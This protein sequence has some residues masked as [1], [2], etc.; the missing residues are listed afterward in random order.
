MGTFLV[1]TYGTNGDVL[2]FIRIGQALR[3]RGHEVVLHT[4]AY[5]GDTARAAGLDFVPVDTEEAYAR[6]LHDAQH[7]LLNVLADVNHLADYYER[8]GLW[9][10]IRQE[11]ESMAALVRERDPAQVVAVSRHT[12]GLSVLMLRE[13]HRVPAAWLALSPTLFMAVP[14]TERLFPRTLAGPANRVRAAAGLSPVDDW[15]PWLSSADLQLGLW[16]RWFDAAGD[17]APDGAALPGFVLHDDAETGALP[18]EVRALVADGVPAERRPVL[19]TGGSGQLLHREWYRVAAEACARAGRPG[20]LVCRHRD[21][22]PESL[23][24]GVLWQPALPFRT[25]MPR[26]AAVVHHGGVLTCARAIASG[27]PQVIL[28]HGTDRPDNAARLRRLGLAEWLP[29]ARWTAS[30]AADLLTRVLDDPGYPARARERAPLVDSAAAVEAAC[31]RL[32]GLLGTRA[33]AV[34]PTT[35]KEASVRDRIQHL[36]PEQRAHLLKRLR[37]VPRPP[38]TEG[39]EERDCSY[40]QRRAWLAAQ[41]DPAAASA[42]VATAIRLRGPLD[43]AALAAAVDEVVAR[44]DGLRTVPVPGPEEP[45]QRVVGALRSPLRVESSVDAARWV[46]RVRADP[47]DL[48]RGPLVRTALLQAGPEESVFLLIGHHFVMDAASLGVVV[49]EVAAAYSARV[50]GGGPAF[51]GP[52]V[53]YPDVATHQRRTLAGGGLERALAHWRSTLDGL[54]PPP[55]LPLPPPATPGDVP[56]EAVRM[57]APELAERLSAAAGGSGR[58]SLAPALLTAYQLLLRRYTARDDVPVGVFAGGRTEPGTERVVGDFTNIVAVRADLGGEPPFPVAVRRVGA[59]LADALAHQDAPFE[60]VVAALAPPRAPGRPALVGFGFSMQDHRLHE[61]AWAGLC[62]DVLP[63][64]A[65]H[66]HVDLTLIAVPTATG[67]VKLVFEYPPGRFD[68]AAV[69]ALATRYHDLL[70]LLAAAPDRPVD[71]AV[72]A[73]IPEPAPLRAA[74]APPP[75]PPVGY[76]A[77]RTEGEDLV[78]GVVAEVLGLDKVGVHHDFFGL[79]GHSLHA[80]RVIGRINAATGLDVPVRLLFVH[81]TV[82][83]LTEALEEL[84]R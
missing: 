58:I 14:L 9:E 49:G 24:E 47:F 51:D 35:A 34:P 80:M 68:A 25:L 33:A 60:A 48:D 69:E 12:S 18:A 52:P 66:S 57:L 42:H 70:R 79:G 77:P 40:H 31:D 5:Y 1:S 7:L 61:I 63:V 16:P 46:A 56:G 67:E 11:Y 10:Q 84:A 21:L 55:A 54:A 62:A 30:A 29:A 44:H 45:R 53:Q 73:G 83:G 15:A 50:T 32:E 64:P 72:L 41:V 36:S 82:A 37:P 28:A 38:R 19:L 65:G 39:E 13:T 23:P 26:V 4:H 20:I 59:A 75:P 71:E 6:T 27:V 43:V 78:A 3:R 76:T 8:N 22:L 74:A 81:P 17:R 2:P